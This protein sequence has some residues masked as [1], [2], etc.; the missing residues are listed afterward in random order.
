MKNCILLLL[1]IAYTTSIFFVSNPY[2]LIIFFIINIALILMLKIPLKRTFTNLYN[3]SFV[4]FITFLF[5][6]LFGYY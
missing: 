6:F 3:F 2:A 4:V 1:F 5:N